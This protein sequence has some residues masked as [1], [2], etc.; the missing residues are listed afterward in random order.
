M[1][2]AEKTAVLGEYSR[3]DGIDLEKMGDGFDGEP[4]INKK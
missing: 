3:C 2:R 1:S 4:G